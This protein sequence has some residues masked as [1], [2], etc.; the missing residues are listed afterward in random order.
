MR[1][2][3]GEVDPATSDEERA[4]WDVPALAEALRRAA[5]MTCNATPGQSGF[6]SAVGPD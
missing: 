6:H 2:H 4:R 1:Q 3:V 5:H